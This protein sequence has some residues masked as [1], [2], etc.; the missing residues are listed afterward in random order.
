M[1]HVQRVKRSAKTKSLVDSGIVIMAMYQTIA[2]MMCNVN[3]RLN[4][5]FIIDYFILLNLMKSR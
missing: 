4:P 2:L 5:G 3:I 1:R